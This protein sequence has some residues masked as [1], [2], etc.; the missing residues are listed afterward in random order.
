[1]VL[2]RPSGGKVVLQAD[3]EP[4][5]RR[6]VGI[7]DTEHP[8]VLVEGPL[9][10]RLEFQGVEGTRDDPS[11]RVVQ[12]RRLLHGGEVDLGQEA[13]DPDDRRR[14]IT[15][16]N[17]IELILLHEQHSQAEVDV[18]ALV[19]AVRDEAR[20]LFDGVPLEVEDEDLV[21]HVRKRGEGSVRAV[22]VREEF[23][24][25]DLAAG[26]ALDGPG[27]IVRVRGLL[28]L[29]HVGI[30]VGAVV[31]VI[32]PVDLDQVSVGGDAEALVDPDPVGFL[33]PLPLE[34]ADTSR[35][36]EADA[37]GPVLSVQVLPEIVELG[38][39]QDLVRNE[40]GIGNVGGAHVV[41]VGI[42]MSPGSCCSA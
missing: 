23:E 22:F 24:E 37:R 20:G 12:I 1:V 34:A 30:R 15:P 38:A 36:D 16:G 26:V 28:V 18:Q 35:P 7:A 14:G 41:L 5:D 19:V 13:R 4:A 3:P 27:L 39:G 11:V 29:V 9:D 33:G 25:I 8:L 10:R 21:R 2:P 31:R 17:R 6:R 42:R 32:A 40:L